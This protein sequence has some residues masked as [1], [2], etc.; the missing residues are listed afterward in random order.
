MH[1]T[2]T[3]ITLKRTN[4]TGSVARRTRQNVTVAPWV[5]FVLA[6]GP[7]VTA[8]WFAGQVESLGASYASLG[9]IVALVAWS[10]LLPFGAHGILTGDVRDRTLVELR[11]GVVRRTLRGVTLVGYLAL[12]GAGGSRAATWANV[13]GL[14]AA[15]AL[16]KAA[17]VL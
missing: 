4:L 5:P 17:G 16:A 12:R 14:V 11:T 13:A 15:V 10:P 3:H 6:A 1:S 7:V 8:F 2:A 9:L